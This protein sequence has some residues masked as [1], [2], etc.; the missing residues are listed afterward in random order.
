MGRASRLFL[1]LPL[2]IAE[3]M[4]TTDTATPG[5]ETAIERNRRR[6]RAWR[7]ENRDR[8]RIYQSNWFAKNR[9]KWNAYQ[10]RKARERRAKKCSERCDVLAA[11]GTPEK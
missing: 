4:D 1:D 11:L 6:Q 3:A 5:D 9:E 7:I 2:A 10:A 8:R